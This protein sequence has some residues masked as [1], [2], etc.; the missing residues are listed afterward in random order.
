MGCRG[1]G[2]KS[3]RMGD[4]AWMEAYQVLLMVGGPCSV[5]P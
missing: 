5:G 4:G 2:L 1:W 3:G